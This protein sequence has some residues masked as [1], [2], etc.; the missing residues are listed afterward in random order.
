MSAAPVPSAAA[1]NWSRAALAGLTFR[2]SDGGDLEFLE[3]VYA[4]TRA[5]ELAIVDWREDEK[6]LIR[7]G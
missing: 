6:T 7:E 4:A 3:R 2:H 1:D 5:D